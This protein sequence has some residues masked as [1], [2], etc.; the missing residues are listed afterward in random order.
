[1]PQKA[2]SFVSLLGTSV[3][4]LQLSRKLSGVGRES[5]V[6][7]LHSFSAWP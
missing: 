6:N 5:E 2:F 1:M 4:P 7:D 3:D